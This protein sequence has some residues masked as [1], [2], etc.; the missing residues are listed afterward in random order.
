MRDF[1]YYTLEIEAAGHFHTGVT[2][3][4]TVIFSSRCENT[5]FRKTLIV[6]IYFHIPYAS[7]GGVVLVKGATLGL[8][9]NTAPHCATRVE[10][11]ELHRRGNFLA[12]ST[13]PQL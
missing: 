1:T 8:V 10:V 5:T 3:Q 6:E 13:A 2:S 4:N 12:V 9:T 7:Y 11:A